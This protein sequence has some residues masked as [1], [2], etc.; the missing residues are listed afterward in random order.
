M[1]T[2]LQR[3]AMVACL[4]SAPARAHGQAPSPLD[5]ACGPM[6][7]KF[8]V[9]EAPPRPS[10]SVPPN[11]GARVVV[12]AETIGTGSGCGF[13]GF[14]PNVGLDG[15]WVGAACAGSY[16]SADVRPGRHRLCVSAG[17]SKPAATI[18]LY[19]FTAEPGA[20]YYFRA[21]MIRPST[22]STVAMHLEPLNADEGW[23][24][25]AYRKSSV[26]RPK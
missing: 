10:L 5:Q 22:P 2:F 7:A 1:K 18:A 14:A 23:L 8:A 25:L 26:S 4:L 6:G 16:I 17:R 11:G 24:L 19:G 15:A 12:F 3:G 9:H 21:E 13:A 20:V